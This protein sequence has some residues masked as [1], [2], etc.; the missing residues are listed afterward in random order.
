[1][2]YTSKSIYWVSGMAI[3]AMVRVDRPVDDWEEDT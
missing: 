3:D 2:N 1:M